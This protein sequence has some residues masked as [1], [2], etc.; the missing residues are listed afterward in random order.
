MTKQFQTKMQQITMLIALLILV[1]VIAQK[2]S[3]GTC[4][5]S[6]YEVMQCDENTSTEI[7]D[8]SSTVSDLPWSPFIAFLTR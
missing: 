6:R 8:I 1:I 5:A 2:V 7:V 4:T 3:A